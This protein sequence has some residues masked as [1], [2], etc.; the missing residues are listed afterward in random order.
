MIS[1]HCLCWHRFH[2]FSFVCNLLSVDNSYSVVRGQILIVVLVALFKIFFSSRFFNLL[3]VLLSAPCHYKIPRFRKYSRNIK[4][5]FGHIDSG[6]IL[7]RLPSPPVPVLF[8]LLTIG[9]DVKLLLVHHADGPSTVA[10]GAV[11]NHF[12]P[13]F[14]QVSLPPLQC[15][16]TSSARC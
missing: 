16:T 6:D 2:K 3:P 9:A 7:C 8:P 14:R 1:C 12:A 5:L 13:S 15:R 11:F 10:A 4:R